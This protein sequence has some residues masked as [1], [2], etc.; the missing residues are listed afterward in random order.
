MKIVNA[1][2]R[3]CG[4]ELSIDPGKTMLFCPYCG[5]KLLIIDGDEVKTER[6]KADA[7]RDVELAREETKREK[8][9]QE[10]EREKEMIEKGDIVK[11]ELERIKSERKT[12]REKHRLE[13][14]AQRI[15]YRQEKRRLFEKSEDRTLAIGIGF[16]MIIFTILIV[17]EYVTIYTP[18]SSKYFNGK[19]YTIVQ[20]QFKDAGFFSVRS[21]AVEDLYNGFLRDD[22][23]RVGTVKEV[24]VGG[25]FEF[26]KNV[27]LSRFTP[28]VIYY[29]DFPKPK[30][31]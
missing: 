8:N 9:R 10:H 28:V 30:D 3:N 17:H 11:I 19:Q 16:L 25:K 1:K 18:E 5:T 6:A 23:K 29:H 2:C 12:E 15:K 21:E 24:S 7:Y 26:K 14:K 13:R 31:G 20:Q 4:A 22:T 27:E